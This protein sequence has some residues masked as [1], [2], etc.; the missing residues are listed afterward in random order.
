MWNLVIKTSQPL[1]FDAYRSE[2]H[3]DEPF[4]VLPAL[5]SQAE[6]AT[7]LD[8]LLAQLQ[9]DGTLASSRFHSRSIPSTYVEKR[10][11]LQALL[12]IRAANPL[13][14]W[15]HAQL[16]Q[17][18]QYEKSQRLITD[19]NDLPR[20]AQAFP[21]SKYTAAAQSVLWQGDITTLKVDAIVNAANDQM[22]GCFQP[23][24]ACIDNVLH[25]A[26]GPRLRDDCATIMKLQGHPEGTGWAK[27]TRGYNL[28]A[29][30]VLHTVGPIIPTG[31]TKVAAQQANQ[32]ADS[33]RACLNLASQ[34]P[35]IHSLAF[36]CISTGV[37]GFPQEPA[38]KIA[39][40]AVANWLTE[41][42]TSIDLVVFNVFT[43]LDRDIYQRKISE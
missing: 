1:P 28:P 2:I 5:E 42:K 7:L 33:Y 36:C 13:P 11:L 8:K 21:R 3:L 19:A 20:V 29:K 27:I 43:N 16:D 17:L 31:Q 9:S 37:F 41:Q 34:I 35:G 15:F 30:Y 23:F 4:K 14:N 10:R 25:T 26:A 18:W 22:R 39:L 6:R 38:A 12:T 24:H 32:L 40:D